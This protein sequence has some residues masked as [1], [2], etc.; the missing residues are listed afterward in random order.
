MSKRDNSELPQTTSCFQ[1]SSVD[2]G[3]IVELRKHRFVK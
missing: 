2:R 3:P 1:Q